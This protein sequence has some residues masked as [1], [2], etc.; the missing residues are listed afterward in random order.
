MAWRAIRGARGGGTSTA[1]RV[2][3]A[4]GKFSKVQFA[5][6]II[7][8]IGSGSSFNSSEGPSD[9]SK[10]NMK[11]WENTFRGQGKNKVGPKRS[12][13][14]ALKKF[15]SFQGRAGGRSKQG[16]ALAREQVTRESK[17]MLERKVMDIR[18][19]SL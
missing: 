12:I 17:R 3:H 16:C 2:H 11:V 19:L 9:S 8:R 18:K 10:H 13:G 15:F 1:R 7:E 5:Q 14:I 4:Y 6:R